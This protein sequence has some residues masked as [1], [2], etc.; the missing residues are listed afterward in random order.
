MYGNRRFQSRKQLKGNAGALLSTFAA[1]ADLERRRRT[2][3]VAAKQ[4]T[5]IRAE[6]KGVGEKRVRARVVPTSIMHLLAR[7][8]KFPGPILWR[9]PTSLVRVSQGTKRWVII[10]HLVHLPNVFLQSNMMRY[11]VSLSPFSVERQMM[12]GRKKPCAQTKTS[13][14]E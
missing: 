13:A 3:D 8:F 12:A 6:W 11:A 4:R 7:A 14:L 10:A 9:G 5:M 2:E 1:G